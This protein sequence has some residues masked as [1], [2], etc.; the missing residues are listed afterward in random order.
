MKTEKR[1]RGAGSFPGAAP[2]P[3]GSS[4]PLPRAAGRRPAGEP[5]Q[6][7]KQAPDRGAR[8]GEAPADTC[9]TPGFALPASAS[10]PRVR[11]KPRLILHAPRR[12]CSAL[13]SPFSLRLQRSAPGAAGRRREAFVTAAPAAACPGAGTRGGRRRG[14]G[15][16]PAQGTQASARLGKTRTGPQAT[17]ESHGR[18]E[19]A[20]A[21]GSLRPG[22]PGAAP[23][24][25]PRGGGS[26][27]G[28]SSGPGGGGAS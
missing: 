16:A 1:E 24:A 22:R 17:R 14:G 10:C 27:A 8:R 2:A 28:L 23:A 3:A 7:S 4:R 18:G 19:R 9:R 12:G 13:R 21:R 15:A 6:A 5:M 25:L 11:P 20:G 26:G